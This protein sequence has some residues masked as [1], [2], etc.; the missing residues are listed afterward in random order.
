M[1]KLNNYYISEF[2]LFCKL[3]YFA[4]LDNIQK[5]WGKKY[6]SETQNSLSFGERPLNTSIYK[7]V[8]DDCV[9]I[10]INIWFEVNG[11]NSKNL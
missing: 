7:I 4:T 3:V 11:E 5:N 8:K 6:I 10:E 9:H 1:C 2:S